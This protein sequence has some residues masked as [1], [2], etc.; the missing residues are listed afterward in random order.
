[1]TKLKAEEL[2]LLRHVVRHKKP[3]LYALVT[4]SAIGPLTI[5]QREE[6]REALADELGDSGFS[7]SGVINTKGR[8]LEALID[9]LGHL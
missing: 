9:H 2:E 6:L 8:M 4:A 7:D 5:A 3:A 1:M